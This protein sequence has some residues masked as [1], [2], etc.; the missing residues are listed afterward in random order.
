M[1]AGRLGRILGIVD[2]ECSPHTLVLV[3]HDDQRTTNQISARGKVRNSDRR[4]GIYERRISKLPVH[5]RK[6][7]AGE[8][9]GEG[10]KRLLTRPGACR[11][12]EEAIGLDHVTSGNRTARRAR[13]PRGAAHHRH[14]EREVIRGIGGSRAGGSAGSQDERDQHRKE[15]SHGQSVLRIVRHRYAR[16]GPAVTGIG[17][18]CLP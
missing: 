11:G 13:Q 6:L 2:Q 12:A 7:L 10:R 17:Y 14:A 18:P 8:V 4:R 16:Q 9:S 1:S 3:R 5:G 15:E